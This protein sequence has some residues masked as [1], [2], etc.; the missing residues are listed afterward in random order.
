MAATI[1]ASGS[2]EKDANGNKKY[3]LCFG[4]KY[5]AQAVA[6][7]AALNAGKPIANLQAIANGPAEGKTYTK[8]EVVD[9]MRRAIAGDKEALE[10]MN[11]A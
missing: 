5:S 8:A 4:P 9:L 3:Y 1:H 2:Y 11:A 6:I 10:F 7:C